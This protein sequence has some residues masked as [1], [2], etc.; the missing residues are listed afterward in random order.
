MQCNVIIAATEM[1]TLSVCKFAIGQRAM[2][3]QTES[4]NILWD[5]ISLLDD[6]TVDFVR[7]STSL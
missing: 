2:L 4:G 6:D 3:L 5:M 7:L 1:L